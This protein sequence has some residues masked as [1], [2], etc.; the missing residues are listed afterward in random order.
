MVSAERYFKGRVF[1]GKD[2]FEEGWVG[3]SQDGKITEVGEGKFSHTG[4]NILEGKDLTI[5][6]GLIDA[7]MH[8][9]GCRYEDIAE[10][11]LISASSP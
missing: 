11:N 8:F 7:H 3:I 4:Q 6:P 10:W 5:L 2:I 1:D 9:F